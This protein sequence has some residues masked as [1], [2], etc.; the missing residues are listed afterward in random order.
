MANARVPNRDDEI[1]VFAYGSLIFEPELAAS[2]LRRQPARLPGYRRAFNKL[3]LRR[4]TPR[5]ESFDAFAEVRSQF[6][7]QG[8]NL[9][10]S[11][12]TVIDPS[13]AIEGEVQIYPGEIEVELLSQLDAREGCD[14][15]RAPEEN[16]YERAVVSLEVEDEVFSGNCL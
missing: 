9:S 10:L 2:M 5:N 15:S 8:E 6:R 12:G 16:G 1:H 14:A 4:S 11:L 3:S 13:A 7:Q